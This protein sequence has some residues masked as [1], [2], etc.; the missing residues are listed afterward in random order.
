MPNKTPEASIILATYEWPEALAL[1][2][3]ALLTQTQKN[4]EVMIADDG[5]DFRT[6]DVI[7][8]YRKRASFPIQHFWQENKGFRKCRIL[9]QAIR[10]AKGRTLIFLDG[11]CVPH[12][13]FVAQHVAL[14]DGKHYVAGR[15]VDLSPEFTKRLDPQAIEKG[16]LNGLPG[17]L[18][19]R[20]GSA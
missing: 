16:V 12:R 3:S 18:F 6:K 20:Q 17:G 2:L 11:D 4:F 14:Q 10:E 19:Q 15:R 13:E 7:E 1:V 9:N 8:A 5:S